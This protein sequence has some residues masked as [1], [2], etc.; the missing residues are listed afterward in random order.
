[1]LEADQNEGTLSGEEAIVRILQPFDQA[2]K[3]VSSTMLLNMINFP[4]SV[5]AKETYKLIKGTFQRRLGDLRVKSTDNPDVAALTRI[6]F[7]LLA[8]RA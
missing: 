6:F 3:C 8:A 2:N 7:V 1:M 5:D 4:I